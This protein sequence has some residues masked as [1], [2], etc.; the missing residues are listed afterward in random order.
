MNLKILTDLCINCK[1]TICCDQYN[2]C[3]MCFISLY[4]TINRVIKKPV[5]K[6]HNNLYFYTHSVL[7]SVRLNKYVC[8]ITLDVKLQHENTMLIK[9]KWQINYYYYY[10][11]I[12]N[13]MLCLLFTLFLLFYQRY[14]I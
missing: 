12:C 6:L 4:N 14:F 13:K 7:K 8:S 10:T 9:C 11:E 3:W 5:I 1:L 2:N